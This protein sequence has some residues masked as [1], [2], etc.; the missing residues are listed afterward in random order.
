MIFGRFKETVF[1]KRGSD[2]ENKLVALEE[3]KNKYPDNDA[4]NEE[5]RMVSLGLKG[6]KEIE[7]ELKDTDIGMYV[8]HD[9]T[10]QID[11]SKAH[12]DYIIITPAYIYLVECKNLVGDV[13]VDQN[14]QFSREFY[15]GDKKISRSMYSP[16]RQAE[17]HKE[18]LKRIWERKKNALMRMVFDDDFDD[19]HKS[20]VVMAKSEGTLKLH[21]APDDIK[22]KV[23]RSDGLVEYLKNDIKIAKMM[24]KNGIGSQ[25]QMKKISD[26]FLMMT[27]SSNNI[28]YKKHYIE[29]FELG[30]K[31]KDF[32][33]GEVADLRKRLLEFRMLK[34]KERGIPAYYVFTDQELDGILANMPR[35]VEKLKALKI[36][37]DVKIKFHGEEIIKIIN[38]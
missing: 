24:G 27:V 12:I 14:G 7:Y 36:M 34:S 11:D 3:L 32:N 8:L 21:Y 19:Y 9:I 30:R 16:V 35:S 26:E 33:A 5:Y 25:K 20:L 10:I 4:L 13:I 22:G 31:Q 38:G 29:A 18:I 37:P 6:E 15:I 23:I 17:K 2:L 1:T 28:D